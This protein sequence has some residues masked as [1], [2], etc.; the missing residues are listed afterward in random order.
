MQIT[1][2]KGANI[3]HKMRMNQIGY[4]HRNFKS[5]WKIRVLTV[6]HKL[7]E[8]IS[9]NQHG[10]N[11]S[12]RKKVIIFSKQNVAQTATYRCDPVKTTKASY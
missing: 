9:Q 8:K 11:A 5:N 12:L 10:K 6:C 7:F 4:T 3:W 2:T 1:I